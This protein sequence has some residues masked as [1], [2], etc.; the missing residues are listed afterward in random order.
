MENI[1]FNHNAESGIESFGLNHEE[2]NRKLAATITVFFAT[3]DDDERRHSKLG[4]FLMNSLTDTE[5]LFLASCHTV[6][7]IK[8]ALAHS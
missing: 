6:D 8:K 4:E 3:M 5:I 7:I 1:Q 2:F